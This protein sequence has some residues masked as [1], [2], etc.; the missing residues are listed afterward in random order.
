MTETDAHVVIL[1]AGHAGGTVAALLRQY[2]WKGP[3]TLLGAEPLPPYQR[4]PLSKQWLRGEADWKSLA[5]RADS[6][7]AANGVA[8]RLGASATALDREAR[9]VTLGTGERLAYDYLVLALGSRSRTLDLPGID[10]PGVLE[11]R[12]VADADALKSALGPGKR[13]AV[14]GGGYI[15]LEAAASARALGADAVVI[16]REARVLARVACPTLSAFFQDYHRARGVELVLDARVEALEALSS[17]VSGVRLSNGRLI[18]CDAVLIGVGALANDELACAAGLACEG[19]IVVDLAARTA[20][21]RVLAIGDCTRRPLPLYGRM[22]RLESVPNALEQAKQ[23]AASLCGRSPPAP[24]VPWFW[25]DQYDIRLQIAG[26]PF[27]A[28]ETVLRGDPASAGFALFH[29]AADNRL[30]AVEAVNAAPEFMAG[31]LMIGRQKQI[32]GARL[33]DMSVSM[34]DLAA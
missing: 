21:P 9:S 30:L 24:E 27:D 5:L 18:A 28:A 15:G 12:T 32:P 8:L 3:I 14:I 33:R 31:R 13:L 4:P 6:F 17:R 1:G 19:G 23:A 11:L 26:L 16:E 34:K 10:L 2:G 7:Y 25:S 22:W 20:D 29:L